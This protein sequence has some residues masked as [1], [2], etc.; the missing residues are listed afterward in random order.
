TK[1][2]SIAVLPFKNVTGDATWDY[3]GIGL[4]DAISSSLS[5]SNDLIV[6]PITTV[7]SHAT[8]DPV[9]AGK[10]LKVENIVDG[11]YQKSGTKI[12]ISVHLTNAQ[13]GVSLWSDQIQRDVKDIFRVQQDIA[14]MLAAPLEAKAGVKQPIRAMEMQT[15]SSEAYFNFM[16]G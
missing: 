9:E 14:T 1:P 6:R 12:R 13:S 4:A 15:Q 5:S 11:L 3:F 16:Q 2:K 10:Q 7:L 8:S